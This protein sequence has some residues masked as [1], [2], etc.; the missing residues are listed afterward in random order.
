M[1]LVNEERNNGSSSGGGGNTEEGGEIEYDEVVDFVRSA[2]RVAT[3]LKNTGTSYND[4]ADA[5]FSSS[6][7]ESQDEEQEKS[8]GE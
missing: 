1:L 2:G 4:F 5:V 3:E 7:G 6:G 8:E